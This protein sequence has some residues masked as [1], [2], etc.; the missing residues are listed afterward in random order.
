MG[1]CCRLVSYEISAHSRLCEHSTWPLFPHS[2]CREHVIVLQGHRSS[3]NVDLTHSL[4]LHKGCFPPVSART[5]HFKCK[6]NM[7]NIILKIFHFKAFGCVPIFNLWK[8][9]CA[10]A[11][12]LHD[13]KE[14]KKTISRR[15]GKQIVFYG[16][17]LNYRT[18]GNFMKL[19]LD[20][21]LR[22]CI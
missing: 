18:C 17:L 8:V 1:K 12:S 2:W 10:I 22:K 11:I 3:N 14:K 5:V 15:V 9:C 7:D 6:I 21:I 20:I 16:E 13:L 19:L 4:L